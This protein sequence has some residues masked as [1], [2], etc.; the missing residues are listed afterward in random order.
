MLRE[1]PF[2]YPKI[3]VCLYTQATT[4]SSCHTD[5]II[6]SGALVLDE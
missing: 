6:L 2:T 3:P 5:S 4:Y 1:N